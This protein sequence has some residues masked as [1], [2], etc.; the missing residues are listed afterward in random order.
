MTDRPDPLASAIHTALSQPEP[1]GAECYLCGNQAGPWL[2]DP[3]GT[4]WPSGA[5]MLICSRRCLNEPTETTEHAAAKDTRTAGES[6]LSSDLLAAIRDAV[7]LP[8][9][10]TADVDDHAW[11]QLMHRRLIDLHA[12]LSVALHPD[13]VASLDPAA[14]AADIRARTAAAP[15]TYT[16][17]QPAALGGGEGQ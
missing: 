12:V 6:T 2:P 11:Q 14:L 10:S 7:H 16:L 1:S 4:T 3:S 17:W 15:V 13:Y 8:L 5:R 9:P